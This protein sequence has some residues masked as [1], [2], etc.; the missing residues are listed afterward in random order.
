MNGT[1]QIE[2]SIGGIE[3]FDVENNSRLLNPSPL[4]SIFKF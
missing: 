1:A 3:G 2:G 4:F